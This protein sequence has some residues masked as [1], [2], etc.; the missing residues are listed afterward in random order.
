M[1]GIAGAVGLEAQRARA[2]VQAMCVQMVPRGPDDGHV[3]IVSDDPS[4][5][6]GSRRLAIIDPTSAGRQPMVDSDRGT[7]IVFN[8]MIYNFRQLRSQLEREG[9]GRNFFRPGDRVRLWGSP[10][11]NPNDNRVHMKRLRRPDGWE[12]RPRRPA[13][14]A[15]GAPTAR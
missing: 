10:A 1:C 8:G 3:A 15:T 6:V 13:A 4:V 9:I 5:V 2:A 7:T 11:R 14:P 12:W